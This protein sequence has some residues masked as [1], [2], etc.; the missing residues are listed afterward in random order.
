MQ[1]CLN[2]SC[3]CNPFVASTIP[4]PEK[5]RLA[6]DAGYRLVELWINELREYEALGGNLADLRRQIDDLGLTVPSVITLFGWQECPPETKPQVIEDVRRRLAMA[7]AV[8]APRIVATPAVT[9]Q[10]E[11]YQLDLDDAAARYRELLELGAEF[12][13]APMMEFLGFCSSVY[14][15][16]TAAA[17]VDLADHPQA[18]LVLDPFHLWR[19]GSGFGRIRWLDAPRIGICHFNDAPA[20][21][22]PRFE[23]QDADRV[24]PGDGDLPL[25]PFL[26]DL[27]AIGYAGPLSLELFNPSHWALPPA[28]NLRR[29]R[30]AMLAVMAEAGL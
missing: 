12:G 8:G 7:A 28:E 13:V 27:R 20:K 21:V 17:I 29:G 24:Y 9:R 19:G 16:E 22:P 4:L 10:P 3:L 23:Q 18:T 2:T 14:Q 26:R 30:E 15:L 25:V 1:P 5:L 6:A 11:W